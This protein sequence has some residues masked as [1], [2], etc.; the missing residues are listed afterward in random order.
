MTFSVDSN[1]EYIILFFCFVPKLVLDN[2]IASQRYNTIY[3]KPFKDSKLSIITPVYNNES[4]VEELAKQAFKI[5]EPLFAEVEYV[6]IDD[7][8]LDDSRNILINLAKK[9]KQVKV[10]THTRNFGQ[11]T[12]LLTGI[13]YSTG[14][15]IFFLDGDLEDNP[16]HL[17]QFV[18][19]MKEGYEIVMAV[20]K[21]THKNIFRTFGASL[22][23][24]IYNF[25]SDYKI[26]HNTCAMR[27]MTKK[28]AG[29]LIRF[30]ERPWIGGFQAWVGLPT[31]LISISIDKISDR[32]NYN[33][34]KLFSHARLGIVGFSTKILRIAFVLGT[35]ISTISSLYGLYMIYIYFT[36][37]VLPGFTSIIALISFF[38]GIQFVFIGILGEY[39]A[40]IFLS[41]KNRPEN[42]I[43]SL[44]NIENE[45]SI[46]KKLNYHYDKQIQPIL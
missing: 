24:S 39:I 4:T 30:K 33:F 27:L 23:S 13:K 5:A 26:I 2:K 46:E 29:Y 16:A 21:N 42:L 37:K 31:G 32:S 25:L 38:M 22:Y 44:Y 1:Y 20:R 15:Y 9:N 28:Y 10:I 7:A 3:M 35:L 17:P 34:F 45:S 40:E 36:I 43:Y 18:E 12:S 14:D 11:H 8:S 6:F 19:R 41:T